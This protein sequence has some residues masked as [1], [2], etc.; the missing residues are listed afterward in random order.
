[1]LCLHLFKFRTHDTPSIQTRT[2]H[3]QF[4]HQI[5]AP[6]LL[7]SVL[8]SRFRLKKILCAMHSD[9]SPLLLLLH[10]TT[11]VLFWE[12]VLVS[13]SSCLW[14]VYYQ[15]NHQNNTRWVLSIQL[16]YTMYICM[17]NSKKNLCFFTRHFFYTGFRYSPNRCL[18]VRNQC[19]NFSLCFSSPHIL[20]TMQYVTFSLSLHFVLRCFPI[21]SC[22]LFIIL[23]ILLL[24]SSSSLYTDVFSH[25]SQDICRLF[26]LKWK[27]CF[28]GWK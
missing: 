15:L 27:H 20:F 12:V 8:Y 16:W 22:P 1:M 24:Y 4:S 13:S 9:I 19:P 10:I 7:V 28:Y 18:Y 14:L 17:Q 2:Q 11:H 26:G 3:T 23:F 5:E 21:N 6:A 25:H